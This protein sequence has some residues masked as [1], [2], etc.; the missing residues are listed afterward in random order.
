M[1]IFIKAEEG[2][3]KE[4]GERQGGIILEHTCSSSD[5]VTK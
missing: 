2:L 1:G 5:S 3:L 4:Q